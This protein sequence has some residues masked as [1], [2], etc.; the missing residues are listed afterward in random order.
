MSSYQSRL[1]VTVESLLHFAESGIPPICV[2]LHQWCHKI[3]TA[4][5]KWC[6]LTA[7]D[8]KPRDNKQQPRNSEA[9]AKSREPDR[10][11]TKQ[12]KRDN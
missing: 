5:D 8:K 7:T 2:M 6:T 11:P 3:S 10:L 1:N 4:F 9:N 12:A